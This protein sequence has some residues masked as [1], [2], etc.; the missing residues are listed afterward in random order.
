MY[1]IGILE[2]DMNMGGELQRFLG[3]NG[4]ESRLI[5][6]EEY[7][8]LREDGLVGMLLNEKLALLLLDIGLP[9]FDGIRICTAFRKKCNTPVIMITGDSNELNE[10]MSIQNGADDFIAKPF[11][12]RILLARM[13]RVLQRTYTTEESA[14]VTQVRLN[15][16][17]SFVLDLLKGRIVA[18]EGQEA[19]LSKNEL[20]ILSI[21]MQKK[22]E[23]VSRE[24]IVN[25]L[26]DS[27]NFVD[28]NTLTVNITRL[29]SKLEQI[30]ITDAIVT[31]RGMGYQLN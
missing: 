27:E 22:G 11:N 3:D 25:A 18:S 29:R 30:G 2:D 13:E 26:W 10:L 9:G 24:E 12:P 21:L 28:D 17:Q 7:R 19:E 14:S 6:P 15:S 8:D 23:I 1:K 5:R 20:Q 4:Y 16:G 31:R